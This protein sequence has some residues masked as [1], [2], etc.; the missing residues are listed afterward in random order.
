M[1]DVHPDD[2]RGALG[3]WA[4]GV[5][6]V[7]AKQN[8]LLYGL[9]ASSFSSVSVNP[10]LVAVNIANGSRFLAMASDSGAFAVSILAS[11]QEHI[12]GAFSKPGRE[13]AAAFGDGISTL[14]WHTGSPIIEGAIAHLDCRFEA[15]HPGGDHTILLGRVV[16]A[17]SDP[18]KKPL[19]YFRRAYRQLL[20]D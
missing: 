7:T 2:F 12:S 10:L 16:G 3:S 4:S 14:E 15:A 6:V 17:A 19:V 11:D 8:G 9:T 20:L 18:G 1:A 5:T 13:P